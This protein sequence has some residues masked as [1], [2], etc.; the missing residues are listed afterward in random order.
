MQ[1]IRFLCC[2]VHRISTILTNQSKGSS[3]RFLKIESM[4]PDGFWPILWQFPEKCTLKYWWY[5]FFLCKGLIYMFIACN[6]FFTIHFVCTIIIQIQ[7]AWSKGIDIDLL[8]IFDIVIKPFHT[9]RVMPKCQAVPSWHI[10]VPSRHIVAHVEQ[11]AH[12]Y[13][14]VITILYS[15]KYMTVEK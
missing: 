6:N 15:W 2:T 11:V 1:S 9:I 14:R 10:I 3:L 4:E 8:A 13:C 7:Q 12:E 5:H